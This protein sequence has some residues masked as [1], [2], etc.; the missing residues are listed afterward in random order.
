MAGGILE[1]TS[2]AWG[3]NSLNLFSLAA[4]VGVAFFV[5]RSERARVPLTA[6]RVPA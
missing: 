3:I 6:N 2:M 4:Y 5:Y 1:Y